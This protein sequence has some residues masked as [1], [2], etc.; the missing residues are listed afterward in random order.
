MRFLAASMEGMVVELEAGPPVSALD[1]GTGG[2]ISWGPPGPNGFGKRPA[3][4][5]AAI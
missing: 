1:A 2:R 5:A 4:T 3:L